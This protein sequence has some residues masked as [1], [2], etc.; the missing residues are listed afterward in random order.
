MKRVTILIAATVGI[1]LTGCR[2]EKKT[3]DTVNGMDAVVQFADSVHDF[4]QIGK[5]TLMKEHV[6]WFTN[7]GTTK[8][9]VLSVDVS[10]RCTH[11]D[12]SKEPVAPG[13]KGWVKVQYDGREASDGYFD[14]SVRIRLN[15]SKL[16][17]LRVKGNRNAGE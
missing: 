15:A 11:A 1:L 9:V 2:N 5:D 7:I 12:Y 3:V 17:Q 13:E 4:G 6:F 14:K 8:A 10:C 16:Y